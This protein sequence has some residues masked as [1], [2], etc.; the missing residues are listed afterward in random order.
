MNKNMIRFN[1]KMGAI[2]RGNSIITSSNGKIEDF[3]YRSAG[4][5]TD[6]E[7]QIVKSDI[8]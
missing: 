7:Y 3:L 8:N 5:I 6:I 4:L 1:S 2:D